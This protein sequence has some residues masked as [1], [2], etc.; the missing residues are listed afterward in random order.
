ML[1]EG[2]DDYDIIMAPGYFWLPKFASSGWLCTLDDM[3][4]S[5]VKLWNV[6]DYD[7]IHPGLRFEL[8]YLGKHFLFPCFSEIQLVFYRADLF[9]KEGV[10]LPKTPVSSEDYLKFARALHN[11]TGLFGTQ[12]KASLA[13]SFPEW[14][15]WF[16]EFGGE[17]FDGEKNPVFNSDAGTKAFEFML[18]LSR[19]CHPEMGSSD[20][21]QILHLMHAGRIGIINHWSGQI[22]PI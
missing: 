1:Q 12:I 2:R 13:E 3:I 8:E 5:N 21:E 17:L 14:L 15:P 19:Y 22:G 10:D 7:D 6:Y 4:Q 9:K 16:S 18:A 20:N 11:P